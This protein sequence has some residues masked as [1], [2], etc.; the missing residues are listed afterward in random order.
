MDENMDENMD[1][2]YSV[3]RSIRSVEP[4]I[5][6]QGFIFGDYTPVSHYE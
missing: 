2:K 5:I 3:A 6:T 4:R 1:E